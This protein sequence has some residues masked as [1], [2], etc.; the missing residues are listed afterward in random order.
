MTKVFITNDI[1]KIFKGDVLENELLSQHTWYQI[2][3]PCDYYCIPDDVENLKWLI[4]YCE[5]NGHRYF[6][7]GKGSNLLI[8]D[9]GMR[10]F[11]IDVSKA[12]SFTRIKDTLVSVGAGVYMPKLV[13]ECEKLGLG[14][15]EMFAGI[16]G[17]VG[18]AI[19]MNAGC[20]GKEMFD[21]LTEV[22]VMKH[23]I[24]ET[25]AKERIEFGYRHVKTFDD[26]SVVILSGTIQ[27]EKTDPE[28]LSERR[29]EFMKKRQQTQPIHLPS[30]GSVFKNPQNDHAARLIEQC[31]L[32]GF[33][34]GNAAVS[35]KHANFIVNEGGAKAADVLQIMKKIKTTVFERF[36][37][38]LEL[39]VK[40]IGFSPDE[41]KNLI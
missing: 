27:L 39:E 3:G 4:D 8:S 28:K 41:L 37:V 9:N 29:K 40:L 6:I 24:A 34:I 26:P 30:S 16:P 21:V 38:S 15:I 12:C 17:S 33:K 23:G 35:T 31:G 2:G 19:K 22:T 18:G 14:G 5:K 20:H 13:L 36:S 11:V 7:H 25:V 1:N 32:K 10:G